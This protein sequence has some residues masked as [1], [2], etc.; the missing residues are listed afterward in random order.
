MARRRRPP[1]QSR[2]HRRARPP[3]RRCRCYR[4][5][6]RSS[7]TRRR[8][9]C[10]STSRGGSTTTSP[11]TTA[12]SSGCSV[13]DSGEIDHR[14][15][16]VPQRLRHLRRLGA[17]MGALPP[18]GPT[19]PW[20]CSG[21]GT[22]STLTA[23]RS[24]GR[25]RPR[26]NTTGCSPAGSAPASTPWRSPA[27]MRRCSSAPACDRSTPAAQRSRRCPSV[28]TTAG[29]RHINTLLRRAARARPRARD[30]HRRPGRV[31]R[32]R[33]DRHRPRLPLGR[34]PRLP[35]RRQAHFRDSRPCSA[36][37]SD[38]SWERSYRPVDNPVTGE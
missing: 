2:P 9:R 20:S 14:S 38:R 36:G 35:A 19:W 10:S 4:D 26:P 11:S 25:V 1:R 33:G 24:R 29:S 28:A 16:R 13:H 3:R 23:R 12:R 31:V 27:P 6:W 18:T 32:G 22:C 8:T 15:T 17:A 21:R 30:V 5:R 37:N 7:A 34:C